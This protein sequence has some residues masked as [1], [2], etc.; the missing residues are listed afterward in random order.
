MLP[1][2]ESDAFAARVAPVDIQTFEK[3]LLLVAKA[4]VYPL[5]AGSNGEAS[6]L[7][8][9]ERVVLIKTARRTLD[10]AGLETMPIIAGTGTGSTRETL[11]LT[12]EA[13]E[14]GADYA[15]VII[16]GYFAGALANNKKALKAYWKEISEKSPIPIMMYN[17]T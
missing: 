11:E 8:H 6:H 5:V 7:T 2:W 1:F 16:S 17:C 4:G 13:A 15:I 3:Q 10:D 9:E 12:K 14:T